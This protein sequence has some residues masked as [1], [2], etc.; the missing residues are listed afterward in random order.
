MDLLTMNDE[1]KLIIYFNDGTKMDVSFPTQIKNSM[2]AL[3]ESLKKVLEADKLLIEAEGRL[4]VI[5]WSSVKCVEASAI[6]A[7]ALPFGV[8]K[9]ARI[10]Q[11]EFIK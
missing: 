2:G 4:I 11:S 10:V 5:P 1:K 7:A 9:G 6:L 8:I 3:V